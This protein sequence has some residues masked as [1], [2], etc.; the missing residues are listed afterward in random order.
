M[1]ALILFL[2]KFASSRLLS[3]KNIMKKTMKLAFQLFGYKISRIYIPGYAKIVKTL[4][5][6]IVLDV[7]ANEGQFSRELR[8]NG[9]TGKIVSF[10]PT[11][12]AHKK[13]VENSR[14]DKNWMTHP[15][16]AVGDR[17]GLIK[18]N[19]AGNNALSSSILNMGDAH[20]DSSPN[21]VYVDKEDVDL[22]TL[23]S[24]FKQYVGYKDKV[25]LKMDVQ[26]Y[27]DQVIMG[28]SESFDRITAI[29]LELSLVSL[30]EGDKLYSFYF[31]KLESLGFTLWDLEAGHRH[32]NSGRLLQFDAVFVRE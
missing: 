5:I 12:S 11:N 18:I 9:Y 23:D 8:E 4:D 31:D 17:T 29:K 14:F 27:E 19:V 20:K 15:R 10:E 1:S 7:G 13:L 32:W 24:V 26:G 6:S 16:A 22:I 28:A 21:S 30:Y 3:N 25:L 2:E